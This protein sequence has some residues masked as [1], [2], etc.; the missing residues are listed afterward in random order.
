MTDMKHIETQINQFISPNATMP[1]EQLHE[2]FRVYAETGMNIIQRLEIQRKMDL[3]NI[4]NRKLLTVDEQIVITSAVEKILES[5]TDLVNDLYLIE[6]S[7][8][9]QI[10]E[11]LSDNSIINRYTVLMA[12]ATILNIADDRWADELNSWG[13]LVNHFKPRKFYTEKFENIA[14]KTNEKLPTETIE[15]SVK[16]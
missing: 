4:V 5:S 9:I 11:A 1:I 13:R 10:N 16:V 15:N 3:T 7:G 8:L 12:T 14:Q 2:Y 6:K